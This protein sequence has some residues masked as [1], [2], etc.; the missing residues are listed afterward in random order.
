MFLFWK[1]SLA[2]I[3]HAPTISTLDALFWHIHNKHLELSSWGLFLDQTRQT[4]SDEVLMLLEIDLSQCLSEAWNSLPLGGITICNYLHSPRIFQWYR[5]TAILTVICSMITTSWL[6]LLPCFISLFPYHCFLG[7]PS[8]YVICTQTLFSEF[9]FGVIQFQII[10]W[11]WNR[12]GN[13]C[14]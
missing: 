4:R 11:V 2:E 13:L 14:L 10:W 7:S 1:V 3:A 6:P 9:S 12:T 5:A 8:K